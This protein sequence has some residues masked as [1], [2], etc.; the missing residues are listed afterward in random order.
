MA[1]PRV[2]TAREALIAELF[3]D[4]SELV[5]KLEALGT[6][7][8]S[9][10]EQAQSDISHA[11]DAA[12]TRIGQAGQKSAADLQNEHK[13]Y[14]ETLKEAAAAISAASSRVSANAKAD[15]R[16]AIL[17]GALAGAA[18]AASGT[19]GGLYLLRH[20]GLT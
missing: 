12:A 1:D 17:L 7:L 19:I 15:R 13:L 18:F 5:T 20:F 8:P 16:Q 6:T 4:A 9:L 2:S 10:V 14:R 3:S 11:A